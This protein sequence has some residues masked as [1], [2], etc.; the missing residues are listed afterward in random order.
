MVKDELDASEPL[1]W[2]RSDI[3]TKSD[4]EIYSCQ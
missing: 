1:K 3:V 4:T 2:S